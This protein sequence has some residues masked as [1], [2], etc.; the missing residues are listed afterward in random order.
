MA[1]KLKTVTI[2]GKTLAEVV[3][4]KPVYVGDDEKD[5][6]FD[7]PH[8]LATIERISASDKA[9][10]QALEAAEAK[11]KSFEGLE[12]PAAAIK[13]LETVKN[14]SAGDLK[15]VAQVEEIKAAAAKAA[16]ERVAAVN[17]ASKEALERATADNE[18]LTKQL[19]SEKIGGSFARSKYIADK[20]I[21]PGPAAEK[22]FGDYFR[23]EDGKIIAYGPDG[24]KVYS[25]SKPGSEAEFEEAVEML[26]DIYPFRDSILKGTGGGTGARN[27][28]G[29][30]AGGNGPKSLTR[31][32]FDK[33]TPVDKSKKMAEGFTVTD[34]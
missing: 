32:E 34:G 26:V 30:G 31:T 28:A 4:G 2:E 19:Y 27:G 29:N 6:P 17:K 5:V 18:K 16:E 15:T 3:D 10:R 25:R 33:L 23:I 20:T 11:L 12:D 22:I 8:A 14:L 7:A 1:L 24:N 9:R 13:A 21:L